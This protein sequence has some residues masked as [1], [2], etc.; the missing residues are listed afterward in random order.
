M[1]YG[2]HGCESIVRD[3]VKPVRRMTGDSRVNSWT[4]LLKDVNP[5]T[6]VSLS[7]IGSTLM[8]TPE[9]RQANDIVSAAS[10]LFGNFLTLNPSLVWSVYE[11]VHLARRLQVQPG[12]PIMSTYR[13]DHDAKEQEEFLI[14]LADPFKLNSAFGGLPIS[15]LFPERLL[16]LYTDVFK[17][18][19]FI[20]LNLFDAQ[21][22]NHL[23]QVNESILAYTPTVFDSKIM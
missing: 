17:K 18:V 23:V 1:G 8:C 6:R 15:K 19:S 9:G 20:S 16:S 11:F 4:A 14:D 21:C 5:E 22:T 7:Y 13:T 10:R 12:Q 3:R 2:Y